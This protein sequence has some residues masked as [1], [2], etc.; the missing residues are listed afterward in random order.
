MEQDR[1]RIITALKAAD[2]AG[3]TEGAKKLASALQSMDF[4]E[5]TEDS[6][7][8]RYEE[9]DKMGFVNKGIA[10]TLGAPVD[11]TNAVLSVVGLG[12][13]V[14]FG[15]SQSIRRGMEK[16]GAPTPDRPPQTFAESVA[17][18]TG[19]AAGAV[20][21][22]GVA[23]KRFKDAKGIG[24]ALA[25]GINQETVK[26]PVR[27]MAAELTAGAGAGAGRS[28]AEQNDFGPTAQFAAE[29]VGG[30]TPSAALT[31]TAILPSRIAVKATKKLGGKAFVPFTTDGAMARAAR[32]VQ[33]LSPDVPAAINRVDNLSNSGL[34]PAGRTGQEGLQ[35]LE[36]AVLRNDPARAQRMSQ[37]TEES[38]NKLEQSILGEDTGARNAP[39]K[40]IESRQ[41]RAVA[42]LD[43]RVERA[44]DEAAMRLE[45]LGD[46]SPEDATIAVRERLESALADAK[47]EENRLWSRIPE[48][49]KAPVRNTISKYQDELRKLSSAQR[50]DMP[51]SA[52]SVIGPRAKRKSGG[53][54]V[55]KTTIK[56]LDGLY[57]KLGEEATQARAAKEFN[58][59]RIAENLRESILDDIANAEG[60]D[61]IQETIQTARAFSRDLNEKFRSGPVGKI[62]GYGR[63]GGP[64]ID[65][66]LAMETTIGA[67]GQRGEIARRAV[68]R[69]TQDDPTALEGMQNYVKGRFMRNVVNNGRVDSSKAQTFIR[70]NTELL[71]AFPGL[72]K[73]LT[74][75][76]TAED[77]RRRV[78]KRGDFFRTAIQQPAQ[79][80]AARVLNTSVGDEM[81]RIFTSN[82][83]PIATV[84]AVKRTLAKDKSG[85]AMKGFKQGASAWLF[86]NTRSQATNRMNGTKLINILEDE[87]KGKA[88]REI[89]SPQEFNRMVR[90]AK[91]IELFQKQQASGRKPVSIIE[92]RPAWLLEK[93]AS[94]GGAVVGGKVTRGSGYGSIQIPGLFS[95]T[96]RQMLRKLTADKAEQILSDSIEDEK[97]FKALLEYRPQSKNKQII[98]ANKR[99]EK[100]LKAWMAGPGSRLFDE[101]EEQEEAP[102]N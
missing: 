11:I 57:K 66:S 26:A 87:V 70:N 75:A 48:K 76:K 82:D 15:G 30:L 97:L 73:Q 40:I 21:P 86:N 43:S 23:A 10:S 56:E 24:G 59:A 29:M 49:A 25:G 100:T 91:V 14:P 80:T 18:G 101:E 83:N 19:E 88:L 84:R 65:P 53:A 95:A 2:A 32:R 62:M 20:L 99:Y 33:E 93:L 77:V 27:A 13:E 50:D 22:V 1:E 44:A 69:A 31:T 60:G 54:T 89:Y 92:D 94:F 68:A 9:A 79:G 63:E 81:S 55:K 71:D 46:I 72:R 37:R 38:L 74:V 90:V 78:T 45:E 12:S 41:K 4:P 7:S 64:K 52:R 28:I 16:I 34:S 67:S 85:E 51:A 8:R 58:K 61:A 3:D 96:S 42:A 39:R 35:D 102:P 47:V 36:D 17:M 6:P 98:D 5:K